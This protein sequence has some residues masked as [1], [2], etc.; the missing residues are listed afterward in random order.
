[1]DPQTIKSKTAVKKNLRLPEIQ[2]FGEWDLCVYFYKDR[3]TGA[4]LKNCCRG[5]CM[6]G[7]Q[8]QRRQ[9]QPLQHRVDD[10]E[11]WFGGCR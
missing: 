7:G 9:E 4:G 6:A 8:Q 5:V 10:L 3:R 1:M 11:S 2:I